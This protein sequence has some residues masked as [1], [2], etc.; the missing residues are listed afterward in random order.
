MVDHTVKRTRSGGPFSRIL[1][2][3]GGVARLSRALE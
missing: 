3:Y 1:S 2:P